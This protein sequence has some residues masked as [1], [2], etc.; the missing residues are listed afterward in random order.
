MITLSVITII[1][2]YQIEGSIQTKRPLQDWIEFEP[3]DQVCAGD[4]AGYALAQG[5]DIRGEKF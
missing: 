5:P 1:S 3:E 4:P 2:F